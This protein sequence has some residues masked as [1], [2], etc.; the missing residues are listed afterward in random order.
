MDVAAGMAGGS[1][2]F[3]DSQPGTR[4]IRAIPQ[5]VDA[6][7]ALHVVELSTAAP[8]KVVLATAPPD[9]QATVCS[10]PFDVRFEDAF[11]N[12]VALEASGTLSFANTTGLAFFTDGTCQSQVTSIPLL[13][14][15]LNATFRVRKN[16]PSP[17]ESFT[18]SFPQLTAATHSIQVVAPGSPVLSVATASPTPYVAGDC[19]LIQVSSALQDGGSYAV[20][21][22]VVTLSRPSNNDAG[23]YAL[24]D[25]A[26]TGSPISAAPFPAGQQSFQV[27]YAD[28]LAGSGR[29]ITATGTHFISGSL[30]LQ[31]QPGPM[32]AIALLNPPATVRAGV[33]TPMF[34]RAFDAYG[35]PTTNTGSATVS[36]FTT[37]TSERITGSSGCG[38]TTTASFSGGVATLYWSAQQLGDTTFT[39]NAG[40][41][42]AST[43]VR[44]DPGPPVKGVMEPVSSWP[45]S[46]SPGDCY[47]P[48]LAIRLEDR[49]G[50][51]TTTPGQLL[52]GVSF[53]RQSGSFC[54]APTLYLGRGPAAGGNNSCT[55]AAVPSVAFAPGEARAFYRIRLSS[56]SANCTYNIGCAAPSMLSCTPPSSTL[57]V[58]CKTAGR[59]CNA[60]QN[61]ECCGGVCSGS[62]C[63]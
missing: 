3:T 39:A 45:T 52:F 51:L 44:V 53:T 33:C 55:G 15:A 54:N 27:R 41:L 29:T 56:Q 34:I 43:G 30:P 12:R 9:V 8:S 48:D 46:S 10:N 6:G 4:Q 62:V 32:A 59:T 1:F 47:G 21:G 2:F 7:L 17:G 58:T 19:N 13:G 23:F 40:G 16:T 31:I 11:G 36:G 49:F 37:L 14:G 18:V 57:Q 38:A 5:G 25:S 24:G 42:L 61:S 63:Q 20:D 26:C 22:R 50:N 35:N 28:R 60:G